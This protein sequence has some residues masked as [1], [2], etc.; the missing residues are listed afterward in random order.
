MEKYNLIL[1]NDFSECKGKVTLKRDDERN[2]IQE[3]TINLVLV[4]KKLVKKCED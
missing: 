1:L 2:T 3:S 4:N